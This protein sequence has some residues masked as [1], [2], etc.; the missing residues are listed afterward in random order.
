MIHLVVSL[1]LLIWLPKIH[2]PGNPSRPFQRRRKLHT[3]HV[4][5]TLTFLTR[6]MCH[7]I[8]LWLWYCEEIW[9]WHYLPC[10]HG[11]V[12]KIPSLS[13]SLMALY[14]CLTPSTNATPSYVRELALTS[15]LRVKSNP[16]H[17][18][19]PTQPT[20]HPYVVLPIA[21][22]D[23]FVSSEGKACQSP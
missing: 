14:F 4:T 20:R 10:P 9:I 11:C 13:I 23:P 17:C 18:T 7:S 16:S 5:L 15:L 22:V 6:S 3:F 12:G 19:W 21:F 1:F 8:R 2:K